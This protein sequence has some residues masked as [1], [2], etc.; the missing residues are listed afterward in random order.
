MCRD[1]SHNPSSE[2]RQLCGH[3]SVGKVTDEDQRAVVLAPA[4][5]A[6]RDNDTLIDECQRLG[7]GLG[8]DEKEGLHRVFHSTLRVRGSD[9][10]CNYQLDKA[11]WN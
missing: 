3:G 2:A 1:D 11:A 6:L 7:V 9:R 4:A 5:R 10:R 8:R